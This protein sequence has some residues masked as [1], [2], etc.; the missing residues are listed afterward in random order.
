MKKGLILF[1]CVCVCVCVCDFKCDSGKGCLGISGL[2]PG[3]T[4]VRALR[5][6]YS[7]V[8]GEREREIFIYF[9]HY[10]SVWSYLFLYNVTSY[11]IYI[12]VLFTFV[13]EN[14][15]EKKEILKKIA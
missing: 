6:V 8:Q 13:T 9:F 11:N 7:G 4:Q 5:Q 14:I 15:R 1:L 2:F 3:M 10:N 12:H